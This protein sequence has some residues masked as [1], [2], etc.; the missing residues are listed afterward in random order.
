MSV[1]DR[2]GLS[3]N[4]AGDQYCREVAPGAYRDTMPSNMMA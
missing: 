3:I 2:M 4:S 1:G